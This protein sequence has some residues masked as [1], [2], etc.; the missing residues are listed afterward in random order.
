MTCKRS[1]VLA[2]SMVAFQCLRVWK[3]I[4]RMRSFLSFVAILSLCWRKVLV[5][6][7]PLHPNGCFISVCRLLSIAISCVESLSWRGSLP[8]SGV[9][10][11]VRFSKLKSVHLSMKA[12]PHLIPV[13]LSS[14]RNTEVFLLQPAIRLFSSS[15]VGMK[16]SLFTDL[17]LGG[18]QVSPCIFRKS[19]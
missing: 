17:Y 3:W 10:S 19:E 12:S 16:G 11:T 9:M 6:C 7:L 18:L 4:F 15:S 13:S 1:L 8:F 14:R 5:K 2:Y